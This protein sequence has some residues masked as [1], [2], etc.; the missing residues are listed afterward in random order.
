M[1][2]L[3][4][5]HQPGALGLRRRP[6]LGLFEARRQPDGKRPLLGISELHFFQRFEIEVEIHDP[7]RRIGIEH[8]GSRLGDDRLALRVEPVESR[9]ERAGFL[10]ALQLADF[11]Q[12]DL[13]LLSILLRDFVAPEIVS[14]DVA[15][16]KPEAAMMRMVLGLTLHDI[17]GV[18]ARNDRAGGGPQRVQVRLGCL[19]PDE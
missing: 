19:R 13:A 15:M 7:Q 9:R 12:H 17:H 11:L 8:H 16:R 10:A 14:I 3:G 6:F 5:P 4:F 1:G 2:C 18:G